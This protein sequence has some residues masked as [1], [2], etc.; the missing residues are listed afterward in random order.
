SVSRD[1]RL[2][3]CLRRYYYQHYASRGGGGAEASEQQRELYVLKWLRNRYMWVGE[4]VHELVQY[5][6]EDFRARAQVDPERLIRRGV[7]RMRVQYSES[8]H[9]RYR[10]RPRLACGLF[11]HEYDEPI[12]RE[13]WRDARDRMERCLRNFFTLPLVEE[14]RATPAYQWLALEDASTFIVDGARILVKPD[15]AWRDEEG[16][17]HL[18]DWKTGIARPEDE[19]LQ[20]AVYAILGQREWGARSGELVGHAA[21]LESGEVRD[22]PIGNE[23]LAWAEDVIRESVNTM[24]NLH[25]SEPPAELF[26]KT[27]DQDACRMCNF[28][29]QCG[30]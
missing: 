2:K 30:R 16:R 23:D 18:V 12:S 4:I 11:E 28:K 20:L 17:V 6:L 13:E 21:Y 22:F 9:R 14:I 24:R 15:F 7:Q 8:L 5:A 19:R 29:R 10:E 1:K 3:T 26:P 25:E 27:E